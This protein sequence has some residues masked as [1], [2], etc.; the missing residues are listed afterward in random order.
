M[1]RIR[2]APPRPEEIRAELDQMVASRAFQD[3]RPLAR[4]LTALIEQALASPGRDEKT[5]ASPSELPALRDRLAEYYKAAGERSRV[6]IEILE[7]SGEPVFF[8]YAAG[9]LMKSP[10]PAMKALA[11]EAG[12]AE[13]RRKWW[14]I[15]LL[16]LI[17]LLMAVLV[18]LSFRQPRAR[19][20]LSSEGLAAPQ[21]QVSE[22]GRDSAA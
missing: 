10:T 15:A 12:L 8:R 7:G 9:D 20:A 3:D 21:A 6:R 1:R 11:R 2:P 5:Q 4:T 19:L 14:P 17:T 22:V 13:R 18:V 16:V